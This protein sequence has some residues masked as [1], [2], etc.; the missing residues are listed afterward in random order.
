MPGTEQES[1]PRWDA[2]SHSE[3]KDGSWLLHH[4]SIDLLRLRSSSEAERCAQ[5]DD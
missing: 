3:K 5:C 1:C 4:I 2:A